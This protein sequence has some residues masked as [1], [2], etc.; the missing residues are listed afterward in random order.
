MTVS[1]GESGTNWYAYV[2]NN[3]L[4]RTDPTGLQDPSGSGSDPLQ[5][6]PVTETNGP[7][8]IRSTPAKEQAAREQLRQSVE[9]ERFATL[10]RDKIGTS[11]EDAGRCSGLITGTLDEMGYAV[12]AASANEMSKGAVQ[13]IVPLPD[14]L[15]AD[16]V[17]L[18]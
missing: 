1:P 15:R 12:P 11:Y 7:Y 3:P 4:T 8:W 10:L 16:R 13:G 18:A 2:G 6:T 9:S 14:V 17:L 5:F